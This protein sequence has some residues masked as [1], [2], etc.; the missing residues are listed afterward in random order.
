[1]SGGGIVGRYSSDGKGAKWK[2]QVPKL[3]LWKTTRGCKLAQ[4]CDHDSQQGPH[5]ACFLVDSVTTGLEKYCGV[6][7][8]KIPNPFPGDPA[9]N[10]VLRFGLY[11]Y[12]FASKL[13][14]KHCLE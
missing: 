12:Q 7:D 3:N 10:E 13:K 9:N 4:A 1:M 14:T 11:Y 5:R 8:I 6:G 2:P